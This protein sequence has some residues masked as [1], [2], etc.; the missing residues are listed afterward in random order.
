MSQ[1]VPD[2]WGIY[3]ESS[4]IPSDSLQ[5]GIVNKSSSDERRVLVGLYS[6]SRDAV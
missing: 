4:V 6:L 3:T 5:N 2:A 1:I